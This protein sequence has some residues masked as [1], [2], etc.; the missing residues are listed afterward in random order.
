MAVGK[1][2]IDG[3]QYDWIHGTYEV[4]IPRLSQS[5]ATA[6]GGHSHVDNGVWKK[7]IKVAI[8][9]DNNGTMNGGYTMRNNLRTTF[10]K[11]TAIGFTTPEGDTYSVF[12]N[13]EIVEKLRYDVDTTGNGLE[14]IVDLDL[15]EA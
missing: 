1:I 13:N 5:K 10:A 4:H 15:I 6:N 14:Y 11:T 3:N 2:T 8:T 9:C 12:F 7:T